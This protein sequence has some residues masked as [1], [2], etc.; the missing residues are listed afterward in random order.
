[1]PLPLKKSAIAEISTFILKW[2]KPRRNNMTKKEFELL[3]K[4]R[5]NKD[6]VIV[7][8]DKGGK[9]VI[10]N[11]CDY[12]DKVEDKLNNADIYE[13]VKDPTN[14]IK[15]KLS[16]ITMKLLKNNKIDAIQK[17]QFMSSDNLAVVKGQPKLH[18][19][20]YPIRI[21]TCSKNSITSNISKFIFMIIK[22][23]RETI[24][25]CV[26]STKEFITNIS[27]I[28]LNGND[29]LIILDI[30]DLFSNIPITRA[31]DI[32][33]N[34]IDRSEKFCESNLTKTDVKQ[35]LLF[36]L[37]NSYFTF[38]GKFFKQKK[39]LPMGNSL[40]PLL[41]DLH[42][43]MDDYITNNLKDVN[44]ED[45]IWRYVD[46]LLI[47]TNMNKEEVQ[48]YTEKLNKIT[49]SIKFTY[50]YEQNKQLNFLDTTLCRN[51]TSKEI[52][53]RWF[54]KTTASD[55]LL[56]YDSCHPPSVKYNIIKNMT[57]RI[58]GTTKDKIKQQEDLNSLKKILLKSNYPTDKIEMPIQ[59]ILR[60]HTH[61]QD[62]T[63]A[64]RTPLTRNKESSYIL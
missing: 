36:C 25:N 34:R 58:I 52:E 11:K 32:V 9:V 55:R 48:T 6:I 4:L 57:E 61:N 49:G 28:K 10:M 38:Q 59:K 22:Q 13:Q 2:K 50:E 30:E 18:K 60:E 44:K 17:L 3:N 20:G 14:T 35:L 31:V 33:L 7:P 54:R 8:A 29:R 63:K 26:T 5:N 51:E 47:I 21:I 23:L 37:Q 43:Y 19:P 1:M 42:V 45:K 16:E 27:K 24:N 56:N 64:N 46:D 62:D 12:I 53:I 39:G 41:A 40:P 15:K